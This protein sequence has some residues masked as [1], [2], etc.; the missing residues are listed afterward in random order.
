[1]LFVHRIA[2][3][4]CSMCCVVVCFKLCVYGYVCSI[5]QCVYTR[6]TSVYCHVWCVCVFVPQVLTLPVDFLSSLRQ[7]E[8]LQ[9]S[10]TLKSS[11]RVKFSR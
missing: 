9:K 8:D 2:N 5:L 6:S 10:V 1:M 3:G 11:G 7:D 4:L